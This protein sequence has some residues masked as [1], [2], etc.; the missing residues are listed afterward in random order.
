M[1]TLSKGASRV[2]WRVD[3]YLND[4]RGKEHITYLHQGMLGFPGTG[5]SEGWSP[6][7]STP[8]Y[9][10]P[11]SPHSDGC[12]H[13]SLVV[14]SQYVEH[15]EEVVYHAEVAETGIILVEARETSEVEHS[16]LRHC[17]KLGRREIE[18]FQALRGT[19]DIAQGP[20]HTSALGRGIRGPEDSSLQAEKN[21]QAVGA[22]TRPVP[23]F[24]MSCG[25]LPAAPRR[26]EWDMIVYSTSLSIPFSLGTGHSA[27]NKQEKWCHSCW[28]PTCAGDALILQESRKRG[29]DSLQPFRLIQF[30]GAKVR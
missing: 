21:P 4:S 1:P 13:I 15:T 26:V 24:K 22:A 9:S 19:N 11:R 2:L 17:C 10:W 28:R 25:L 5:K 7:T 3:E 27:K 18:G 6:K 12:I 30:L 20:P 29:V 23:T 16:V 8:A 14:L